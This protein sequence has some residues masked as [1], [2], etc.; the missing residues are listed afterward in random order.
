MALNMAVRMLHPGAFSLFKCSCFMVHFLLS[1]NF[2]T[3]KCN[4]LSHPAFSRDLGS[5]QSLGFLQGP[6]RTQGL[7]YEYWE[8]HLSLDYPGYQ[9]CAREG[10]SHTQD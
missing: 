3:F 8:V 9:D 10:P 6:D 5:R 7:H 4:V 2:T 1:V